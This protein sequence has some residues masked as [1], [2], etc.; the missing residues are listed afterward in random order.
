[1]NRQPVEFKID[2]QRY[3]VIYVGHKGYSQVVRFRTDFL[4]LATIKDGEK[5]KLLSI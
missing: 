4:Y 1:M 5:F 3:D 2:I